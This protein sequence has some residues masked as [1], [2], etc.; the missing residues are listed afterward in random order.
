M[1]PTPSLRPVKAR[2]TMSMEAVMVARWFD[3]LQED[4]REMVLAIIGMHQD[5]SKKTRLFERVIGGVE[6]R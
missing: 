3:S 6:P 2:A 5:T 4:Q 1:N